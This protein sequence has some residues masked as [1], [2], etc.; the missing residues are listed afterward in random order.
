MVQT[1]LVLLQIEARASGHFV[2]LREKRRL[3]KPTQERFCADQHI[4]WRSLSEQVE[5]SCA[6]RCIGDLIRNRLNAPLLDH[7]I[8]IDVLGRERS[9]PAKDRDQ[10]KPF[11]HGPTLY[12]KLSGFTSIF[13]LRVSYRCAAWAMR[14]AL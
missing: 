2:S 12:K 8:G 14:I 13:D 6:L 7:G 10:P 3:R 9:P 4:R 1:G 11:P 5:K